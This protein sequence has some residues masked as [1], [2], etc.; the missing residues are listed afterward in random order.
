MIGIQLDLP[1]PNMMNKLKSYMDELCEDKELNIMG[2]TLIFGIATN[3]KMPGKFGTRRNN[4]YYEYLYNECKYILR[5]YFPTFTWNQIFLHFNYCAHKHIDKCGND[6]E[7]LIIS[8]GDYEGGNLVMIDE[9]GVENELETKNRVSYTLGGR[10]NHFNKPI[11]G[12]KYS[13]CVAT[14]PETEVRFGDHPAFA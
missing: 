7:V 2:G 4:W 6:D 12:K 9:E 10:Y 11:T 13:F 3:P 14:L 8:F 1:E 5:E